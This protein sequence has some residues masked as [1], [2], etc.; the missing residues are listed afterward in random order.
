MPDATS[1]ER[2]ARLIDVSSVETLNVTGPTVQLLTTPDE[3]NNAPCVMRG[4]VASGVVVPLHSHPDPETF[5]HISGELDGIRQGGEGLEGVHIQPGDFFHIPGGVKHAFGIMGASRRSRSSSPPR[6]SATS[7]G[8]SARRSTLE[9]RR[10]VH[11]Q[12]R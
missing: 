5:V 8:K 1:R 10:R 4:I 11:H 7:F 9:H 3:E 12:G 2:T 6:S